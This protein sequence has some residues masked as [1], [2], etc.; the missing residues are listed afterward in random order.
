MGKVFGYPKFDENGEKILTTYDNEYSAMM[1]DIRVYR[2]KAGETRSFRKEGEE[3]AVLL[4]AGKIVFRLMD[5]RRKS[6]G[7]MYLPKA[8]GPCMCARDRSSVTAVA[9][10]EILVQCT[11]NEKAF[12]AVC[13][14]PRM[15]PGV[16]PVSA[17]SA[18]WPRDGS[19][20]FSITIS[21]PVQHG[22]GRGAQ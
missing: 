11:K 6:P 18:M 21:L 1:M 10:S 16:I 5:R 3:T 22:S 17:S 8:P 15:R 20:R 19:T 14:R 13:I 12:T 4:L 9:D 2:M 7:R